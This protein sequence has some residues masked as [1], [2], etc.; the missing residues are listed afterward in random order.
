MNLVIFTL[1]NV[2][3]AVETKHVNEVVP[4]PYITK[5]G[6]LPSCVCG[7][8]D[9][10]GTAVPIIDLKER[11]NLSKASFDLDNDVI[12]VTHNRKKIGFIVDDVI[13]VEDIDETTFIP[14]PQMMSGIDIAFMSAA[15]QSKKGLVIK[16]DLGN[17]LKL[18]D[19][20]VAEMGVDLERLNS[21][22]S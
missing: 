3:Y 21:L 20:S 1:D 15:F 7:I 6:N 17:I 2:C 8:V 14:P 22:E 12:I 4:I 9:F 16:L 11:I 10:R 5:L 13:S 18:E 19:I